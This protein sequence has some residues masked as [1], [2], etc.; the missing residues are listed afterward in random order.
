MD[1]DHGLVLLEDVVIL[2]HVSAVVLITVVVVEDQEE[3]F[4]REHHKTFLDLHPSSTQKEIT[5][6]EVVEV[7]A[8]VVI[9]VKGKFNF[10]II[11]FGTMIFRGARGM[12][13]GGRGRGGQW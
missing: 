5:D 13:R 1:Q 8:A 4:N 10:F 7:I 6:S 11:L 9:L 2:V 3:D 12:G